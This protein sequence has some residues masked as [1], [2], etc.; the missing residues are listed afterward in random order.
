MV[1]T[2][3]A[4]AKGK[5]AQQLRFSLAYDHLRLPRAGGVVAFRQRAVVAPGVIRR[6][7]HVARSLPSPF[8]GGCGAPDVVL[9]GE[10]IA[11]LQASAR[12]KTG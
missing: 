4:F 5:R 1:V 7:I 8:T 10:M 3:A 6:A 2:D 11:L 9:A 12:L